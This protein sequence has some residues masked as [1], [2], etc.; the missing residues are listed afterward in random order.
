LPGMDA[1]KGKPAPP[2]FVQ[3][4][5]RPVPLLAGPSDQPIA[6]VFFP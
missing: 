6:C 4:P 2:H 5:N 1:R 3:K